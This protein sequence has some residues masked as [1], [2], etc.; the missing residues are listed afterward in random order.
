MVI[1]MRNAVI[2][3]AIRTPIGKNRGALKDWRAD[4]LLG[5]VINTL[6]ERNKSIKCHITL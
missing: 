1:T 3:D 4:D 5:L 2:L 6:L